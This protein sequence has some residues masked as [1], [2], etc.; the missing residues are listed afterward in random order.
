MHRA[1]RQTAFFRAR[2]TRLWRGRKCEGSGLNI[3]HLF[4]LFRLSGLFSLFGREHVGRAEPKPQD[5]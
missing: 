4:R 5:P 2:L 3:K 1:T